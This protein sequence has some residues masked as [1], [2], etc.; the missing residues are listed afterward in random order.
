VAQ[1]GQSFGPY[2][3][4]QIAQ[5]ITQGRIQR[6]TTVWTPGMAGWAPA[7]SIE[8]LA[9]LFDTPPPPLESD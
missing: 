4:L 1:G 7:A 9:S 2:T 6:D 3:Q 8:A 5:A